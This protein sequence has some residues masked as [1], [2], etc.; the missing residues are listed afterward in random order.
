[1]AFVIFASLQMCLRVLPVPFNF[2]HIV[3]FLL[4]KYLGDF[5]AFIKSDSGEKP[6]MVG[7]EF[8]LFIVLNS[9]RQ[10]VTIET[11]V[12]ECAKFK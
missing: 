12:N 9:G 3:D 5:F 10:D 11:S 7:F 1:M 8:E 4:C 2:C 6:Q